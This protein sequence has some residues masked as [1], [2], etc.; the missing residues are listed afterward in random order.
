MYEDIE[1]HAAAFDNLRKTLASPDGD[2]GVM[3]I[4]KALEAT[5]TKIAETRGATEVDRDKLSKL[6]RGFHAASRVI[7][8]LHERQSMLI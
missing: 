8:H 6:Y 3:A 5:A 1:K 2:A 4:R 7:A